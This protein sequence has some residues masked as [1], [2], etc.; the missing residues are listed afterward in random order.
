MTGKSNARSKS[1]WLSCLPKGCHGIL[2]GYS[3]WVCKTVRHNLATQ[4]QQCNI[5]RLDNHLEL[6]ISKVGRWMASGEVCGVERCE[7][8]V[9][10]SGNVQVATCLGG[11]GVGEMEEIHQEIIH[12]RQTG[13]SY[14]GF[15]MASWNVWFY[16]LTERRLKSF[17]Q[18]SSE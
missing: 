7:E 4:Q 1:S 13:S 3:P 2:A 5:V 10:T 8:T 15:W 11:G 16:S 6:N 12:E 17:N 14:I 18:E 9:C